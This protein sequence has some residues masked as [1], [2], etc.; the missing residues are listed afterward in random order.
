[1][2]ME[3]N[4]EKKPELF[5]RITGLARALN[6]YYLQYLPSS[7]TQVNFEVTAMLRCVS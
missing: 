2:E 7:W 6:I 3:L 4:E 1:M 5:G